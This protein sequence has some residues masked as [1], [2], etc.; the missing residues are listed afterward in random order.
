VGFVGC[1]DCIAANN[2]MINPDIWLMRILQE[3]TSTAEYEFLPASNCTFANNLVYFSHG[4]IRTYVNVGPDTSAETFTFT[5]NLWYAH[6][7]PGQSQP[8]NLPAA[9][10]DPVVGQDPGF[11]NA[12]GHNYHIGS[13]SPAAGEGI[14]LTEVNGDM[15][16][17]CY[18]DPPAIGAYEER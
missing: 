17:R 4:Q 15:D 14:P 3:T 12:A 2:T 11:E 10:I 9:D 1:V 16:G 5:N 6:D 8:D 7:S 18:A 13:D